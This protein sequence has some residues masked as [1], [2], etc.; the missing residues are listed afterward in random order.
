M[1]DIVIL[2]LS[3]I[4]IKAKG[5]D[6]NSENI[7]NAFVE[8]I[9]KIVKENV[10]WHPE[11]IC[12]SGDIAYSGLSDQYIQ[13]GEYITG[14]REALNIDEHHVMMV[15]GN[16]DLT[17]PSSLTPGNNSEYTQ[18]VQQYEEDV[19]KFF[20]GGQLLPQKLVQTYE[21]YSNFRK[22]YFD[23]ET[24][25]LDCSY[26]TIDLFKNSKIHYLTGYKI[27][28][29]GSK[30]VFFELNNTWHYL[31]ESKGIIKTGRVKF[32]KRVFRQLKK[33]IEDLKSAHYTI[34]TLFHHPLY[35][36]DP[37]EY[38][39]AREDYCLYDDIIALSDLCFAGHTHGP[40]G[41][42]PDWLGNQCQ[43]ILNGA[44]YDRNPDT[45]AKE[46]AKRKVSE[47]RLF[48][49][50]KKE[51]IKQTENPIADCSATLVRIDAVNNTLERKHICYKHRNEH[52]EVSD[53]DTVPFH[54]N[55][56]KADK[57][58][59]Q[60]DTLLK[61]KLIEMKN[62]TADNEDGKVDLENQLVVRELFG[63]NKL[64]KSE[65]GDWVLH[66]N[67]QSVYDICFTD[68]RGEFETTIQERLNAH[69]ESGWHTPLIVA[70]KVSDGLQDSFKQNY[71]NFKERF[72]D[73]ILK[74]EMYVFL[75]RI[76]KK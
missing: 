75:C 71:I 67:E 25:H 6:E 21:N 62:Y 4:H 76:R 12:I 8:K 36:L 65:S 58:A 52:W 22:E 64:K 68:M 17:I 11:Y 14:L 2:S 3:D 26:E 51:K 32:E 30:V 35:L 53:T 42:T 59:S 74:G 5:E 41:K 66:L 33:R 50:R 48:R 10:E 69:K 44:F 49:C 73:F 40:V 28:T 55:F 15:A 1:K 20:D 63:K 24:K 61:Y 72:S 31:P 56:N 19:N 54:Y 60:K 34:I 46:K 38:Q 27:F 23:K 13:A 70:C 45:E 57:I 9:Q 7:R 39:S 47:Y 16:H 43:Y 29:D 18:Y 37:S